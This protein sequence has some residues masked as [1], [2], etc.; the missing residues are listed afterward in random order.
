MASI[1]VRDAQAGDHYRVNGEGVVSVCLPMDMGADVCIGLDG[2]DTPERG[3]GL[4][5]LEANL[6]TLPHYREA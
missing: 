2:E 5:G 6:R 1:I 4:A 3:E